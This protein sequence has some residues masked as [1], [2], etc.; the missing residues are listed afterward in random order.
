MFHQLAPRKKNFFFLE[1]IFQTRVCYEYEAVKQT[2]VSDSERTILTLR[3]HSIDSIDALSLSLS[4]GRLNQLW[5]VFRSA[6][7]FIRVQ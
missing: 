4:A 5:S 1:R 3:E 7:M 2:A 6:I